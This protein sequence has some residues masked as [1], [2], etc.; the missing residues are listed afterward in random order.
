M[1]EVDSLL[2]I[3]KVGPKLEVVRRLDRPVLARAL[4]LGSFEGT[5]G[6]GFIVG[7]F[8]SRGVNIAGTSDVLKINISYWSVLE[9]RLLS[10]VWIVASFSSYSSSHQIWQTI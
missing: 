10:L 3:V 4:F 2:G 8:M 9:K 6:L 1:V 7:F 5:S